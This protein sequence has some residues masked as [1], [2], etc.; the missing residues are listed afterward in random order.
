MLVKQI[1]AIRNRKAEANREAN[2]LKRQEDEALQARGADAKR[3]RRSI[4]H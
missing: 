1:K 2:R 4:G 3:L